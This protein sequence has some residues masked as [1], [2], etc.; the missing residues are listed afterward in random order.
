M[1]REPRRVW[2]HEICVEEIR[3]PR[4]VLTVNCSKGTYIRTLC[5]DIGALLGC[6]GAMSSLRRTMAAGFTLDQAVT[7]EE[8]QRQGAALLL[9]ADSLF[10]DA[11]VLLLKSESAER[12]VRCGGPI[13]L[14][15]TPDGTYRIYGQDRQFL[16]LTRAKGGTL[17]S[18]KN[19]FGA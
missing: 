4:V 10:T 11:P 3:L 6:G 15:G 8:V 16:C 17:T 2:I 7:L 9:P 18:I 13:T 12:R 19:F 1:E 14:P 5:H